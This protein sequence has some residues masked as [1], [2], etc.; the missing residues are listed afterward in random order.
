MNQLSKECHKNDQKCSTRLCSDQRTDCWEKGCWSQIQPLL[1]VLTTAGVRTGAAHEHLCAA[2]LLRVTEDTQ[3][4]PWQEARKNLASIFSFLFLLL[5]QSRNNI[6]RR[7]N[8]DGDYLF[9]ARK[10]RHLVELLLTRIRWWTSNLR[11][12]A[13]MGIAVHTLARLLW[14][15]TSIVKYSWNQ[16][17]LSPSYSKHDVT[18][19]WQMALKRINPNMLFILQDFYSVSQI[20]LLQQWNY[21]KWL[22]TFSS[23]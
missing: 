23:K 22:I 5:I 4:K 10:I 7:A 13:Q 21:Y 9:F 12:P 8:L 15:S 2:V 6:Y 1:Q 19:L 20:W 17:V 3:A 16:P 11:E 18:G 14:K